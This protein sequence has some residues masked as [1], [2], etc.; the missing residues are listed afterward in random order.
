MFKKKS[1]N[2]ESDG[3]TMVENTASEHGGSGGMHRG[4]FRQYQINMRHRQILTEL[5]VSIVLGTAVIATTGTSLSVF[6]SPKSPALSFSCSCT[7]ASLRVNP[8]SIVPG[9]IITSRRTRSYA[10]ARNN[11]IPLSIFSAPSTRSWNYLQSRSSPFCPS[12]AATRGCCISACSKAPI[13]PTPA[14]RC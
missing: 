14:M 4:Q 13:R 11:A 12:P 7:P 1:G 6:V 3:P 5:L 10:S 9:G 2:K 8:S